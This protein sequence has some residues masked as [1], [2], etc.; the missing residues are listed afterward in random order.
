MVIDATGLDHRQLNVRI[1]A[2]LA[3]GQRI[4]ELTHVNGQRYIAAGLRD[5]A[6]IIVN[7]V[8]GNDLAAFM[9]GPTI[10][11][12]AN[13][14]DAVGNTMN[15]GKVVVHGDA[16]DVIGYAMRGGRIFIKGDVGYRV[17][18]H[19][20]SY[21]DQV[22]A[23]VIGGRARDFLGEY[24]A[25]GI[26][27]LLGLNGAGAHPIAGSYTGT[28]MHG[29]AIYLR[30]QLADHML[31]KEVKSFGLDDNDKKVVDGLLQ[32]FFVHFAAGSGAV[33]LKDIVKLVPVSHRP[34]GRLY[35]Y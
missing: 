5:Q 23:V 31:G 11:V 14:Q 8:A 27:V 22:P 24:M 6:E 30:G 25:G 35:A 20:K 34:Y 21:Q 33:D 13:A 32:E 2:A 17:G 18:I 19:M 3:D 1:R 4:L 9:D 26:L 16:R 7:G 15:A 29:G 12:K 28:G 10:I